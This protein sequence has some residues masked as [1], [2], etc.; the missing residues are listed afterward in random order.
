MTEDTY[1]HEPEGTD[2][3]VD[4]AAESNREF[5]RSGW[6]LVGVLLVAFVVAPLVVYIDPPALPFKFTYLV[7]PL[8]PAFLLGATAVW[9]AQR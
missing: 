9:A 7:V 4:S 5:G 8:V 2:E 1:R 3:T 6:I